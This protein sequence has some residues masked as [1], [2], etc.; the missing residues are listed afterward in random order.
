M[1]KKITFWAKKYVPKKVH[2]SFRSS[3]GER[4]S[5]TATK[6]VPKEV[7]VSFWAS[8]SSKKKQE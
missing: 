7:K 3:D 8:K 4:V 6:K 2:V 1:R 5:F